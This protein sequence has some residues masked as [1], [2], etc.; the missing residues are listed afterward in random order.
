MDLFRY[1]CLSL[2]I[3]DVCLL[4]LC[5]HLLGRTDLLAFL[6]VMFVFLSLPIRCPVSGVVLDCIYSRSLPSSLLLAND[7][8]D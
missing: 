4:Q 7:D 5:G 8:I 2:P 3:L 1:L 6:Y